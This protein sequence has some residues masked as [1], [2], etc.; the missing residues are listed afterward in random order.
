MDSDKEKLAS[1]MEPLESA[2]KW[3]WQVQ[4]FEEEVERRM[5]A[6][7]MDS[8]RTFRADDAEDN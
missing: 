1:D 6:V 4:R 3:A 7:G 8:K 2:D 5:D